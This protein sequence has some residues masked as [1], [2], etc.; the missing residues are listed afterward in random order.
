MDCS[1]DLLLYVGVWGCGYDSKKDLDAA[2]F[3][4]VHDILFSKHIS[5]SATLTPN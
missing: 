4:F 3:L 2:S 1:L 5:I